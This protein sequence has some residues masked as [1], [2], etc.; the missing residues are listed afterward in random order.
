MILKNPDLHYHFFGFIMEVLIQLLSHKFK[1]TIKITWATLKKNSYLIYKL[2]CM[3][4]HITEKCFLIF[5]K[6]LVEITD[7]EEVVV[8]VEVSEVVG[9][10]EEEGVEDLI[11]NLEQQKN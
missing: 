11:E 2:V 10:E 4:C 8:V 3:L 9:D 1:K 6:D 5:C 7:E